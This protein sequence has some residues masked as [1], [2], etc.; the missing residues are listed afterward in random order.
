MYFVDVFLSIMFRRKRA[1]GTIESKQL[2][3]NS[4]SASG[5]NPRSLKVKGV[6]DHFYKTA[7]FTP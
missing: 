7:T 6:H 2:Y 5:H 4:A 1:S 3:P